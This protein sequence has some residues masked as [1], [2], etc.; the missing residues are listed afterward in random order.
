MDINY[1]GEFPSLNTK[2]DGFEATAPVI[3]MIIIYNS[4]KNYL[5]FIVRLIILNKTNLEL[6]TLLEMYGNG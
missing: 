4:V 6:K 2:E 5:K 1:Q 3:L